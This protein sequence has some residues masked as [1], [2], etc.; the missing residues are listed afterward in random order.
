MSEVQGL[1]QGATI[2]PEE[3][4]ISTSRCAGTEIFAVIIML[5]LRLFGLLPASITLILTEASLL[6][7]KFETIIPSPTKKRGSTIV[8]LLGGGKPPMGLAAF[9]SALKSLSVPQFLWLIELHLKKAQIKD[10]NEC[11]VWVDGVAGTAA[12]PTS[13]DNNSTSANA[14][15]E[16]IVPRQQSRPSTSPPGQEAHTRANGVVYKP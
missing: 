11:D 2:S 12:R 1:M 14:E 5:A 6:P 7:G 16:T 13:P 10:K 3:L 8:E 9:R 4:P 15:P